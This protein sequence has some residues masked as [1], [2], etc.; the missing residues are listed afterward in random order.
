MA[1][2]NSIIKADKPREKAASF[3]VAMIHYSKL[4]PS[5]RNNYSVD[6][7]Q[8]LANAIRL[9]GGI[10]QNLLARK[11]SPDEYELIAGHRRRLAIEYLVKELGLN[12]YAMVPV[13]VEREGDLLSEVNLILTNCGTRE[14]SDW[15]KMMEV[16]RLTELLKAMQ[17]GSKEEQ[18]RFQALFGKEPGI[19]GRELRGLVAE[20]L[21]LSETKVAQLNHINRNLIPELKERFREGQI[22][23]SAAN[24]A[25]SLA[26]EEQQEL[27]GKKTIRMADVAERK[28]VQ[29]SGI[30]TGYENRLVSECDTD[31]KE[32]EEQIP[33]QHV[34]TEYLDQK[35]AE[36]NPFDNFPWKPVSESD[37]EKGAIISESCI[38]KEGST[39]KLDTEERENKEE[40]PFL[41]VLR[42]DKQRA[43]FIDGYEKWPL[44]IETEQTGERYYRYD[45]PDG[46]AMVVKVYHA[47]L[48]DYNARTEKWEDRFQEGY[49][50]HE[51]YLLEKGKFFKDCEKNRTA[52]IEK[53]KEVQRKNKEAMGEA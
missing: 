41:P 16:E 23:I 30:N 6:N 1:L 34:I 10:K 22:G 12:E 18:E 39:P 26:Q 9:S 32:I 45:L 11:K 40:Q 25:A 48:F 53:L 14:R 21:G 28:P 42:N 29:E 46:T 17:D 27:A 8:E 5:E 35:E 4:I 47:M 44:W 52:L 50:R 7:I 33:G 3:P 51:Y 38:G 24:G 37:T 15:E 19:G 13:H 31:T 49:G 43:A 2:L 36:P 20:S